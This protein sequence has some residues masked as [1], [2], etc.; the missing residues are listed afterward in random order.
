MNNQNQPN[1]NSNNNKKILII[2]C[3]YLFLSLS[4]KYSKSEAN[5]QIKILNK[6][7]TG[8][9]QISVADAIS[10]FELEENYIGIWNDLS[11]EQNSNSILD[12]KMGKFEMKATHVVNFNE[13][14]RY[15]LQF[16]IYNGEYIDGGV[17]SFAFYIED[18]NF[19]SLKNN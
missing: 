5:S 16:N 12:K 11:K 15:I 19:T 2:I 18:N 8:A 14:P 13:G 10:A 7:I 9:N 1:N 6:L 4:S 17:L 3:I